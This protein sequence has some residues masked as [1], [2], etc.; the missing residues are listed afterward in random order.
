MMQTA[1]ASSV[2]LLESSLECLANVGMAKPYAP[3]S[4]GYWMWTALGKGA[5]W[6]PSSL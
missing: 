6:G 1:L 5:H 2:E 4:I 3:T